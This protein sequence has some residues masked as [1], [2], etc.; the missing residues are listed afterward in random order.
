LKSAD[1]SRWYSAIH[2]EADGLLRAL[3]ERIPSLDE[4]PAAAARELLT[5]SERLLARIRELCSGTITGAKIRHHGN[6]H[7]G[8]VLL[9]ADDFLITGFEGDASLPLE[10][11]RSK[12]S[13]LRDVA[14]VLRS[15]DYARA[16]ALERAGMGRP[17]LRD[18]LA[19][20]LDDWLRQTTGF[21]LKGYRRA[22]VE[23]N[24]VPTDDATFAA[25]TTLFQ[26]Q[27]ALHEL[28]RELEHRPSW[29]E[30]PSRALLSSL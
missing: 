14:T 21:F 8:K 25:L 18:P 20:A 26:I 9:I 1:Q 3:R 15:F 24:C 19:P 4:R 11:R 30:V 10:E 5:N 27:C 16:T 28:R 12:D 22:A 17:D 6:L 13:P 2:F 7:L 23:S 29:I